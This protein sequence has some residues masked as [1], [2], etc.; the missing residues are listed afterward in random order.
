MDQ[1][2]GHKKYVKKL[3]ATYEIDEMDKWNALRDG[4][5]KKCFSKKLRKIIWDGLVMCDEG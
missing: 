3:S 5:R 4:A 2:I 1:H